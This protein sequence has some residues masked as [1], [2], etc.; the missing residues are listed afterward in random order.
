MPIT[1]PQTTHWMK[2]VIKDDNDLLFIYVYVFVCTFFRIL[3]PPT[4]RVHGLLS[5]FSCLF[6]CL[7]TSLATDKLVKAMD[8]TPTLY[9]SLLRKMM[10]SS[11]VFIKT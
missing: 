4:S 9:L 8:E 6:L 7:T 5:F 3:N 1:P 11:I 10:M 2:G